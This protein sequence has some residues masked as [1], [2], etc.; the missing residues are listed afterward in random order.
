MAVGELWYGVERSKDSAEENKRLAEK[1]I[2]RF[3]SLPFDDRAALE[4]ARARA[5][6]ALIGKPVGSHDLIVA[7]IAIANNLTV[8]THNT[9]DF[10]NIP[11]LR[12][13]DWQRE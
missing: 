4:W 10:A 11:G 2:G 9:K 8:V 3:V 7:S 13:E 6:L 1:I 5:A 12:I